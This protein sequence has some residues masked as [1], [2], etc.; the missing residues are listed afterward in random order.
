[1]MLRPAAAV[2]RLA[3]TG[4]W[5]GFAADEDGF[6]LA[7]SRPGGRT[8][9]SMSGGSSQLG[10]L[11]A[12]AILYFEEALEPPP[13]E[14]EATQADLAEL[15]SWMAAQ[16][17]GGAR[18]LLRQALDAI[19]DGL[20][21]DSVVTRLSEVRAQFGPEMEE[22]ADVIDL[23]ETRMRDPDGWSAVGEAAPSV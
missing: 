22:Q 23:L 12:L 9:I 6:H 8:A 5:V 13:P 20:A 10:E 15:L 21:G 18:R 1:M 19:D 16:A 2:G 14:I 4:P 11:A 3:P 7:R 17:D